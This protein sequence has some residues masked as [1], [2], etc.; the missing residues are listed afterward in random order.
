M[1]PSQG[2]SGFLPGLIGGFQPQPQ[3]V[4]QVCRP[5]EVPGAGRLREGVQQKR[6][7]R[8]PPLRMMLLKQL[9]TDGVGVG[10]KDKEVAW[11]HLFDRS[12]DLDPELNH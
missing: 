3:M 5:P 7:G 12:S 4:A 10:D 2:G 11:E 1:R 9:A 8:G 6:K